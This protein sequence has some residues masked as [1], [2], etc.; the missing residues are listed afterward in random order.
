MKTAPHG[1]DGIGHGIERH[2]DPKPTAAARGGKHRPGQHPQ[3][4]QGHA[5]DAVIALRGICPPCDRETERGEADR[6]ELQGQKNERQID[7]APGKARQGSQR[8]QGQRLKRGDGHAPQSL[9]QH[10]RSA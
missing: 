6:G 4:D 3:G 7:R 5:H 10:Q 9:S 8:H 2:Q 1:G